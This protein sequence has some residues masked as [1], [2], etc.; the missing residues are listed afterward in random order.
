MLLTNGLPRRNTSIPRRRRCTALLL[1]ASWTS[2]SVSA[3]LVRITVQL[4]RLFSAGRPDRINVGELIG[5]QP[6]S[7]PCDDRFQN[8]SGN[9]QGLADFQPFRIINALLI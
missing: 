6:T 7:V 2:E 1:K 4:Q 5:H 9:N 8:L 3:L